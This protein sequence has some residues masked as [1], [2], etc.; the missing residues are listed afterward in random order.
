MSSV[1]NSGDDCRRLVNSVM[2]LPYSC[3]C[4][5]GLNSDV[6]AFASTVVTVSGGLLPHGAPVSTI[7]VIIHVGESSV[8]ETAAI[9]VSMLLQL[10]LPGIQLIE[11]LEIVDSPVSATCAGIT[12]GPMKLGH[13]LN[14]IS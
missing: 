4:E 9:T 11:G 1:V 12:A 5:N 3:L 6:I 2:V 13:K 7:S 8:R 14:S 10:I